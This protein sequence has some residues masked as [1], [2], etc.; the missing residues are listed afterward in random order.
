MITREELLEKLGEIPGLK[1]QDAGEAIGLI[2]KTD[3]YVNPE[4]GQNILLIF[5]Q[6]DEDGEYLKLQCPMAWKIK[7]RNVDDFLR[8]CMMIQWRTKLIQ[9]EYDESDGEIRPMIEW[10]IEDGTVTVKQ[11]IRA[12]Y[13]MKH[14][15]D[16]YAPVLDRAL[17]TGKVDM[18][19]L[20]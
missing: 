12:I 1:P 6:L 3:K 2:F 11:L 9:F 7:G 14:L 15:V 19:A 8:A 5:L 20:R 4:T 13:G 16:D 17:E 10:P 18:P